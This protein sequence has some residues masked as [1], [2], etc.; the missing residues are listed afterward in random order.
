MCSFKKNN[1]RYNQ[2]RINTIPPLRIH[3][4]RDIG[5]SRMDTGGESRMMHMN[6]VGPSEA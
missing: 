2:K 1:V 4:R 6:Q 5:K 3:T